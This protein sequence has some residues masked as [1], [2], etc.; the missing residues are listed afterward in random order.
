MA[1]FKM[2][3][4]KKVDLPTIL[5]DG[6]TYFCTDTGEIFIDFLDEQGEVARKQVSAET[7]E[8]KLKLKDT[9]VDTIEDR[10]NLVT[11]KV[12]MKVY[13]SM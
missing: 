9:V 6:Y 3:R 5:T 2:L 7:E 12:H 1:R 10:N 4:G 11:E 8:L 13:R